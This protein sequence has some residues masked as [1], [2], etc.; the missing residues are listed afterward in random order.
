M[1]GKLFILLSIFSLHSL[2]ASCD[3][4]SL[5]II[6]YN[7]WQVPLVSK[8]AK[9]R[10]RFLMSEISKFGADVIA[11]QE[12]WTQG[13]KNLIKKDAFRFGYEYQYERKPKT[14]VKGLGNGL[15]VLSKCPFLPNEEAAVDF[16]EHTAPEEIFSKKGSLDV[17]LFLKDYKSV[18]LL[19]TH[20]G[21]VRFS[22]NNYNS[23]DE[24]KRKK[25]LLQLLESV[26][27][28]SPS[29]LRPTILLGDFNKHAYD[30]DAE[31]SAFGNI[32]S[33]SYQWLTSSGFSDAR[34]HKRMSKN[35]AYTYS[36]ENSYLID[37]EEPDSTLDYIFVRGPLEVRQSS[38][39]LDQPSELS[40]SFLS[41]HFGIYVNI[42]I[43]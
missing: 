20:L 23:S 10:K 27:A 33:E 4:A 36:K 8:D 13:S 17:T 5:K 1:R 41:D 11:L 14:F 25:Q 30:W 21:A 26:R 22:K 42:S 43:H 29:K 31:D 2:A 7:I 39:I 15:L 32:L 34:P 37:K 19:N 18:R 6:T 35:I 9:L 3:P 12:V 40:G 24:K 38:R 28:D 16:K